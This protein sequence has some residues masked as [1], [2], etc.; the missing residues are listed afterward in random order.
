MEAVQIFNV[1][2]PETVL[3]DVEPFDSKETMFQLLCRKFLEAKV[4]TSTDEF[5]EALNYRE[6][7]G[8]TY[9]GHGIAIPH[10]KSKAV[11][12]PGICFCRCREGFSY[13]SHDEV[14]QVTLI[15]MLAIP[16]EQPAEEYLQTLASLARLLMH[17]KFVELLHHVG[18]YQELS[19][20][21]R[22]YK[23]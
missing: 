10:G 19:Q 8:S 1:L 22:E 20:L 11:V 9:M 4:I 15:F 17:D 21:I 23:V 13:K 14:G 7:L 5:T 16:E 2:S 12:K 6:S 18:S 3:L